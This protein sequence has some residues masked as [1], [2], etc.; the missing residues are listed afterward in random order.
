MI[1]NYTSTGLYSDTNHDYSVIVSG[2]VNMEVNLIA[3][4]SDQTGA[5]QTN[6][7]S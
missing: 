6:G 3:V 1:N 4:A 7:T 2:T 5:V